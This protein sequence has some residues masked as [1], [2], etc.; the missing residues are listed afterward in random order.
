MKLEE[1]V[2][3][4]LTQNRYRAGFP[5]ELDIPKVL[6]DYCWGL[7]RD[8]ERIGKEQGVNLYLR[9]DKLEIDTTVFQGTASGI[10]IQ[11]DT[12]NDNFGDLHCHPSNSIGHVDGYAAHSGEDFMAI[13]NNT[14]K[15]VF[16][17]FVASGTHIYAAIYRSGHSTV[18]N[19]QIVPI[20]DDVTNKAI[21]FFDKYCPVDEPTRTKAMLAMGSS[22]QMDQYLLQRRRETPGLGKK[23]ERLSISGCKDIARAGNFGF[24]AGDQGH[25]ISVWLY[26]YLQLNLQ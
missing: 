18:D 14:A 10:D 25:G 7:Y 21:K 9:H 6:V 26:G 8:G 11:N 15:P 13:R 22:K 17:R 20:R 24:Y 16:I 5:T 1:Y 12:T 19:G 2:S 4:I 3:E 23:M